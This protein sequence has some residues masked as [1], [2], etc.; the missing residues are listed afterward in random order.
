MAKFCGKCGS[1]LDEDTGLCPRCDADRLEQQKQ[2]QAARAAE[3]S[4]SNAEP[5]KPLSRKTGKKQEKAAGKAEKKKAGKAQR[6]AWPRGKRVRR[7]LL[8]GLLAI[9]LLAVLAGGIVFALNYFGLV[10][11]PLVTDLLERAGWSTAETPAASDFSVLEGKFTSVVIQDAQSAIRAARTG[12]KKMGL[13]DA[14]EELSVD[15]I[16]QTEAFSYYRLQQNYQGYPVYGKSF[17]VIADSDGEAAGIT[18]NCFA[19]SVDQMQPDITQQ[20]A[21]DAIRS[22]LLELLG[23]DTLEQLEVETLADDRLC[24]YTR[25]DHSARLAYRLCADTEYGPF[26]VFVDARS[27]EVL[28]CQESAVFAQ[29]EFTC[30]G[31]KRTHTFTAEA[32]ERQNQMRYLAPDGTS[33]TVYTPAA[34]HRTDWYNDGNAEVVSWTDTAAPDRSA[35]D[36]MYHVSQVYNYYRDY[37]GRSSFDGNGEAIDVYVHTTAYRDFGGK[38]RKMVNNAYFWRSPNGPII[39]FTRCYD[40]DREIDEYSCELD[41][42]GHEFTHGVVSYTAQLSDT[43]NNRMPSAINE[44]VADIMGYCAEAKILGRRIDWTSSVRSSIKDRN[45]NARS[46]YH[47]SDYKGSSME[48]HRASTIVSYAAYMMN[49]SKSG[50][51]RDDEIAS[52]W[53]HSILTLPSNCTFQALRQHVEM[54][55]RNLKLS[56]K[57]RQCI[58]RAFDAVGIG[59]ELSEADAEYGTMMD[60]SV[61]DYQSAPYDD[62]TITVDGVYNT[63]WFGWSW[64]GAFQESYHAQYEVHS[65]YEQTLSLPDHGEYTITITDNQGSP[66]V[67]QKPIKVEKKHD[68]STISFATSYGEAEI[69]ETRGGSYSPADIPEGAVEFNGHYYYL[70]DVSG[71]AA[72]NVNT[73]ESAQEYCAGVSGYLATITS[74]EE[75]DFLYDYITRMG[76][77]DAFFGLTDAAAE[78]I[79]TWVTGEAMDY[80]NWHAGEPNNDGG[81]EDYGSFF[82]KNTDGTWN[83]GRFGNDTSAFL[84]EWGEYEIAPENRRGEPE[85]HERNIV[86]VLDSSGSMDGKPMQE[87]KKAAVKFIETALEEDAAVGV[88]T[89]DSAAYCSAD[90]SDDWLELEHAV[91]AIYSAGSTNIEDGLRQAW[92]M[93]DAGKA[94]K[95]TLVLMSD[96]APNVGLQGDELVAYADEIKSAGVRIY[97]LGFFSSTGGSKSA[98]QLLMEQL[99]SDGCHYEVANADDLVFFFQDMADQISGQKYIY[100]RIACP[101]D[102]SV[103]YQG[104][105]LSSAQ[106]EL[107]LRT[108]FGTL[109]FEENDAA[110]DGEDDRVKVLRLKEGAEYDLLLEGTGRGTMDYTIGFM[111]DDGS[112]SDLR[113][114]RRIKITRKTVINTVAAVSEQS[115]LNIDEDGDGR[116]DL[117]L[118]AEENSY[119]KEVKSYTLVY[120]AVGGALLLIAAVLIL[121]VKI[122]RKRRKVS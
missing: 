16:T 84:C 54:T 70:Y 68:N 89:Y 120:A 74:Q 31:Q 39:S 58:A 76:C 75:N 121:T 22:S 119:G 106:D 69:D 21:D 67:Y 57:K 59:T 73:W 78:G 92:A 86:L 1:R 9:L 113:R 108:D 55:A 43:E 29:R 40:G 71:L 110:E 45:Q 34:G 104:Q 91:S 49:I 87:T 28:F 112:Y 26:E 105:T 64:F 30:Q 116:V 93:L 65:D 61:Y 101:V 114:F 117:R 94:E 98:E 109:T 11:L 13:A 44:A 56:E 3:H 18:S 41:V 46:I 81:D 77:T 23:A 4:Q 35:V 115:T 62:Y 96:G 99:A 111:D 37:L 25:D 10:E 88:V 38:D 52:L 47:V 102:V 82:Y 100:V 17:V 66:E 118:R 36:A 14:A 50:A 122:R 103:S 7:A 5:E 60:L 6:A 12:A 33:I 32:G 97:T 24:I 20:E 53:Y 83:D 48:C 51:L 80:T 85:P 79:W 2:E 27:A 107:N 72:H 95:K 15:S 19:V 8:E 42:V 90:F 63:G